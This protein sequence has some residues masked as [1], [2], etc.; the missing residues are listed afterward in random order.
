MYVCLFDIDGT[1]LSS[2]GAG[3]AALEE[4]LAD[5]FGVRGTMEK[6][7]LG[8]R[9]DTAIIRDLLQMSGLADTPEHRARLPHNKEA[10][11]WQE[12]RCCSR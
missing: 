11:D 6:L 4:G 5:A 7:V 10:A 3:K 2:G 1:L 8:G 12:F 9:T